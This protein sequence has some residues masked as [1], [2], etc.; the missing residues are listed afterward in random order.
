MSEQP[1]LKPV[2]QQLLKTVETVATEI[3][4]QNVTGWDQLTMNPRAD[5]ACAVLADHVTEL[6]TPVSSYDHAIDDAHIVALA[7]QVLADCVVAEN[8]GTQ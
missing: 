6:L 1:E 2:L 5:M 3:V 7:A 8:G 4:A